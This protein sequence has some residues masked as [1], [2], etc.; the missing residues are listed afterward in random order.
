LDENNLRANLEA[1]Q[2]EQQENSPLTR[3]QADKASTEKAIASVET[4]QYNLL[5]ASQQGTFPLHLLERESREL[6]D[7]RKGLLG[8]LSSIQGQID[9]YC[10]ISDGSIDTVVSFA[11]TIRESLEELDL[12]RDSSEVKQILELLDVKV[13]LLYN[14]ETKERG[15]RVDCHILSSIMPDVTILSRKVT[16]SITLDNI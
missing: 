12:F 9:S 10:P 6:E 15:C 14:A 4:E 16:L 2:R 8:E 7:R 3:L 1:V 5:K 13:T 11:D